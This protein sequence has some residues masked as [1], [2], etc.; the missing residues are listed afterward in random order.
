MQNEEC[1]ITPD[2]HKELS[3]KITSIINN[4]ELYSRLCEDIKDTKKELSWDRI[5][6]RTVELYN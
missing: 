3:S 5:A 6:A 2:D 1:I 4:K